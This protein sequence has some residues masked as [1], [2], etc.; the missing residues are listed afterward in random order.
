MPFVCFKWECSRASPPSAARA[1][2]GSSPSPPPPAL[3]PP[4]GAPGGRSA[5]GGAAVQCQEKRCPV[6]P[7]SGRRSG[8]WHRGLR[9]LIQQNKRQTNRDATFT[10]D[11]NNRNQ[12]SSFNSGDRPSREQQH[13][14]GALEGTVVSEQWAG[15]GA[16]QALLLCIRQLHRSTPQSAP[17]LLTIISSTTLSLLRLHLA[18]LKC[19][20]C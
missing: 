8:C 14:G 1:L 5:R 13:S 7:C 2:Q 6:V 3:Q 19:N 12:S 17:H 10:T 4:G 9:Q 15:L 20:S 18:I 16:R 11:S